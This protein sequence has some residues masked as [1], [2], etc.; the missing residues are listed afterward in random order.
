MSADP[1]LQIY[2]IVDAGEQDR[3]TFFKTATQFSK[4]PTRMRSGNNQSVKKTL[5]KTL[6]QKTN[7]FLPNYN[8]N[9]MMRRY[10]GSQL[11]LQKKTTNEII[12]S[13]TFRPISGARKQNTS[14]RKKEV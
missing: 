12:K 5:E 8:K 13:S 6:S 9:H 2:Y 10:E 3:T 11:Y 4:H 14:K 7:C 1:N